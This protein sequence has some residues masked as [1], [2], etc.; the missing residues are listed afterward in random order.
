MSNVMRF[1]VLRKKESRK[2]GGEADFAYVGDA[3]VFVAIERES[4]LILA[5]DLASA[6]SVPPR[7]S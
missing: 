5:H 2:H 4:K 3:W 1:G 6:R 7:D